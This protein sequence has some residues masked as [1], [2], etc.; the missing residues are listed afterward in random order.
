MDTKHH[1]EPSLNEPLLCEL[2]EALNREDED[3]DPDKVVGCNVQIIQKQSR[4][5]NLPNDWAH[6]I[7]HLFLLESSLKP[8]S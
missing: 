8:I 7:R 6:L 5:A 4:L 3:Q 2:V 1:S